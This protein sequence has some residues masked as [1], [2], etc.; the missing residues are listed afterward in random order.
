[1]RIP[2]GNK[3]GIKALTNIEIIEVQIGTD[4]VEEDI[5]RIFMDWGDVE[6]HCI[7]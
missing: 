7:K 3:H 4:F 2:L 6:Q 1:M 5:I